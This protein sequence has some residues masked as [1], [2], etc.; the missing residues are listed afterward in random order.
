MA[1]AASVAV[2]VP[3]A[4]APLMVNVAAVFPGATDTALTA[5][6]GTPLTTRSPAC[7]V[8]GLDVDARAG[9]LERGQEDA[10]GGVVARQHRVAG[11]AVGVGRQRAAID[12]RRGGGEGV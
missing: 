4:V 1:P 2:S 12:E 11:V 9:E 5:A 7:T 6:P 10:A 8:A 3:S